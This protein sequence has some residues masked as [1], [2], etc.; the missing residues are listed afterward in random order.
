[1]NGFHAVRSIVDRIMAPL[2][3]IL[4]ATTIA[5][6]AVVAAAPSSPVVGSTNSVSNPPIRRPATSPATVPLFTNLSF[7]VAG[8]QTFQYTPPS[9]FGGKWAK[10]ILV[11]DFSAT[12][13]QTTKSVQ[14]LI[15]HA[16]LLFGATAQTLDAIQLEETIDIAPILTN[17]SNS[18]RVEQDVTDAISVLNAANSGEIILSDF[19][20]YGDVSL[21]SPLSGIF[22]VT[23]HL[24]FYPVDGPSLSVSMPDI[25]KPFPDVAG[26]AVQ[27]NGG[28]QALS[29]TIS[30]PRNIERAYLDVVAQGNG[31]DELWFMGVGSGQITQDEGGLIRVPADVPYREI[32][33]SIDGKPAGIA[34]IAPLIPPHIMSNIPSFLGAPGYGGLW[35][36]IPATQALTIVPYRVDLTPFAALLSDGNQH[37]I[38]LSVYRA[39]NGFL[40][41][42]NLYLYLDKESQQVTGGITTNSLALP[43]GINVQNNVQILPGDGFYSGIAKGS[44][45][46]AATPSY[47]VEGYINSS[48]G[49]V[50]T[51]VQQTI[52]SFNHQNIAFYGGEYTQSHQD[53]SVDLSAYKTVRTKSL[54]G[55]EQQEFAYRY[56][57]RFSTDG[58][59]CPDGGCDHQNTGAELS[60][61]AS[62]IVKWNGLTVYS[63]ES[64]TDTKN[65]PGGGGRPAVYSQVYSASDSTGYHYSRDVESNATSVTSVTEK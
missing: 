35:L 9:S 61:L 18:W 60:Y 25:V 31:N 50:T 52:K 15:G 20:G 54:L 8:S 44:A 17:Q 30:L 23:A 39:D 19:H 57:L 22:T 6:L 27:L 41:S 42:G 49:V 12:K 24:E 40:I 64:S 4:I 53:I 62:E 28:N 58:A 5:P 45:Q 59:S 37:Q 55:V 7:S 33:V 56:P 14:I 16:G 46:F 32:D 21:G 29:A 47:F 3:L 26:G 11:A 2:S 65:Y 1:M 10:V 36:I 63:G 34:P 13:V 48:H 43:T 38:S 51:S